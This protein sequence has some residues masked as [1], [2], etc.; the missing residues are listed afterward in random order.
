MK[1]PTFLRTLGDE[2]DKLAL[3][4]SFVLGITLILVFKAIY[5]PL[6]VIF[7]VL[8]IVSYT[9]YIALTK[10][11]AGISVDRASDNAYYLGLIFTLFSLSLALIK[12]ASDGEDPG[13]Q[14]DVLALLSD[15]GIALFS[16]IA[17][18]ICRIILQQ[19]RN[20]P[21]DVEN[22]AREEL[23]VA[24]RQLKSSISTVTGSL[25]TL[26]EATRLSL[27]ELNTKVATVL[28]QTA[29]DNAKTIKKV[30][31][32]LTRLGEESEGQVSKISNFSSKVLEEI[33]SVLG[34]L[35]KE[36][37]KISESPK[38]FQKSLEDLSENFRV[39]TENSETSSEKQVELAAALQDMAYKLKRIF[40]EKDF[41]DIGSFA[42]ETTEKLQGLN[43]EIEQSGD[44]IKKLNEKKQ[45]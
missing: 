14:I 40:S 10:N 19:L 11:R 38:A 4:I 1:R 22:E 31:D 7:A 2:N 13:R 23:G 29:D 8:V 37:E 42:K 41:K 39:I 17:G 18:I 28:E 45:R 20:D 33:S 30:S 27:T 5:P 3:G 35:T 26:S 25:N 6:A 32:N 44:D 15:F 43:N 21:M 34:A 16:T 12:L 36:M 9:I 24:V